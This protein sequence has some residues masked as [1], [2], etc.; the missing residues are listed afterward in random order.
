[1][2]IQRVFSIWNAQLPPHAANRIVEIN[3]K[4]IDFKLE[5]NAPGEIGSEI[6]MIDSDLKSII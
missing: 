6:A 3:D 4:I 1:M 5:S 2:W